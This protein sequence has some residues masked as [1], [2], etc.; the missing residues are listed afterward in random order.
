MGVFIPPSLIL[1]LGS[2]FLPE[3]PSF[4]YRSGNVTKA[5][6]TLQQLRGSD[7]NIE[8]EW[9]LIET[10]VKESK[11]HGYPSQQ[12][13]TLLSR[14]YRGELTVA[15]FVAISSQLTGIN[16]MLYYTPE[17]FKSLGHDTGLLQAVA[18]AAV[19]LMGAITSVFVIDRVGRRPLL[20]TGGILLFVLQ[21]ATSLVLLFGFDPYS[22]NDAS[23]PV[24]S[25]L[26]ALICMFT[27]CFGWSWGP[28][29]WLVPVE[30]QSQTTRS[31][32]STM[33]VVTNFFTVFLTTQFFLPMLCALQ[34]GT[35]LI[36][37]A[38]DVAMVLFA[39]GLLVETKG[40]PVEDMRKTFESHSYWKKYAVEVVETSE[41]D[42]LLLSYGSVDL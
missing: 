18:V 11:K 19:L 14:P 4:L 39:W 31:A 10:D 29:G 22:S 33:S 3:T 26:L 9:R 34:W 30:C 32:A 42:S 35:F 36:F 5:R 8:D 20:I 40:I 27:F 25:V 12:L 41:K 2:I 13:K 17:L 7:A 21:V 28:L 37:A 6:Q 15:C 38:F 1:L 24:S 23:T 16:S